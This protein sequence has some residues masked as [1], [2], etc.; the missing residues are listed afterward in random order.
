MDFICIS[1]SNSK[2][3]NLLPENFVELVKQNSGR[4]ELGMYNTKKDSSMIWGMN[5]GKSLRR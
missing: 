3:E 4:N 2:V 5:E 1:L